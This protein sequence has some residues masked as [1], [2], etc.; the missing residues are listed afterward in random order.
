LISAVTALL[1]SGSEPI[2]LEGLLDVPVPE[3]AIIPRRCDATFVETIQD[4]LLDTDLDL[5]DACLRFDMRHFPEIWVELARSFDAQGAELMGDDSP[6]SRSY[7]VQQ[8]PCD[9]YVV[10][11]LSTP[12]RGARR[13]NSGQ[14]WDGLG[15]IVLLKMVPTEC[16]T[17]D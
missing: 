15:Y 3:H 7:R 12:T 11:S 1:L 17:G 10:K 2:L 9:A 14:L 8:E 5:A 4:E 13:S 6:A 16:N